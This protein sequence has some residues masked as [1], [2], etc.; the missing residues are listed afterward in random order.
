MKKA[1]DKKIYSKTEA[2]Y[3]L[4][5]I[6]NK[7]RDGEGPIYITDRGNTQAVIISYDEYKKQNQPVK[8]RKKFSELGLIGIW[9]GRKDIKDG[10][11]W[12][13]KIRKEESN[14]SYDL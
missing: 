4:P 2:R 5:D 6:V 8:K 13:R 9:K 14:R 11:S 7:V 1:A 12:E 3:N 10:V